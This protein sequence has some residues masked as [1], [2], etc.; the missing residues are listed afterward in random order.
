MNNDRYQII[1]GSC[2]PKIVNLVVDTDLLLQSRVSA[3]LIR[4]KGFA[5]DNLVEDL[6]SYKTLKML[7]DG[8]KNGATEGLVEDIGALSC[9]IFFM[10]LHFHY[11]NGLIVTSKHWSLY[12]WTYMI[13]FTT[14]EGLNITPK[15]NLV[16]KTIS[17]IFLVLCSDVIKCRM[18][19]SEPEEHVFL[20]DENSL[21]ILLI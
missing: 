21:Q 12:L 10:N 6:C 3:Y 17:N 5:S 11:V 15:R 1:G 8:V 7:S 4:I 13:W 16:S 18:S 14:L 19:T 2:I 9:T 20:Y